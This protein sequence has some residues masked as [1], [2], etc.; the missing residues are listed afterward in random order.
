MF[1][2]NIVSK[3]FG[4]FASKEFPKPIQK[5]LN[6]SYVK[7]LGLD[8]SE[9]RPPSTYKTLNKLF[10]RELKAQ[11]DFDKT[12]QTIISPTDS[13]V[14]AMGDIENEMALQIKGMSYNIFD[15]LTVYTN[16]NQSKL[17]DGKFINF[18][19][20][21]KITIDTTWFMIVKY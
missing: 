18:Y 7:L 8:M 20:S 12:Q 21:Q 5:I 19:L 16:K 4:K 9:F 3:I 6:N 14:S 13:F 11:R 15:L 2:T 17:T 10:T 1:C